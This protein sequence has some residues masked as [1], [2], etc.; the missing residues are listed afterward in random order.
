MR[1][2]EAGL[3][4]V[5]VDGKLYEFEKWGADD[6]LDV[7]IDL[8]QIVGGP[9]GQAI[10][11]VF[12][13]EGV[14]Q[15]IDAGML[16]FVVEG[17]LKNMKKDIVKPLIKKLSSEKVL[18]DGRPVK[19]NVHYADDLMHLFRVVKAALEVQYGNF[20]VA[21]QGAVGLSRTQR[22]ASTLAEAM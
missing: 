1:K 7:L 6:S 11:S 21:F 16:G 14:N 22:K 20:F 19:F 8:A 12:S 13:K 10:G 17:L 15:E 18:C 3:I 9:V 4:E 5:E 2:N